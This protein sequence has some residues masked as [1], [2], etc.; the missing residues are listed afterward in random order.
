M[1]T[2]SS[3]HTLRLVFVRGGKQLISR[4]TIKSSIL[5]ETKGG[6]GNKPERMSGREIG[7]VGG[8]TT[9]KS[10]GGLTDHSRVILAQVFVSAVILNLAPLPACLPNLGYR[11]HTDT[12]S[13]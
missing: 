4:M 12:P 2:L 13:D 9:W 6:R 11:D 3:A 5:A 10:E 7:R 8:I 1:G